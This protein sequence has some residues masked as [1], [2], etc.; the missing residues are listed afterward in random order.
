MP[1][2][3]GNPLWASGACLQ[4]QSAGRCQFEMYT[5]QL[6]LSEREYAGSPEL[7]GWC[8]IHKNQYY[9]PEWL[10]KRWGMNVEDEALGLMRAAGVRRNPLG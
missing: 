3:H 10:L 5:Q 4:Y 7:R 6:G 8:D 2:R 1:R 9:V